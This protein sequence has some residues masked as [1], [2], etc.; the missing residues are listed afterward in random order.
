M[1]RIAAGCASTGAAQG[2]LRDATGY[3]GRA[4]ADIPSE[5][6]ISLMPGLVV[7]SHD[8]SGDSETVM[9]HGHSGQCG[10][11]HATGEAEFPEMRGTRY[12][13]W[14]RIRE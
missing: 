4:E 8:T 11:R 3:R 13:L 10:D 6:P 2:N 1:I 14:I 7:T 5:S 12:A 9:V